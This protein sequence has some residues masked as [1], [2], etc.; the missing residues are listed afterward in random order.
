M[1][2]DIYEIDLLATGTATITLTDDGTG[3]DWLVMTGF[4]T[5]ATD[6]RLGWTRP[7]GTSTSASGYYFTPSTSG[8]I[9][10]RLVVNGLIENV[11]GSNGAD[12]IQGNEVGN[13]LYGDALSGG[14]GGNDTISAGEGNDSIYAGS[15]T[16]T[17]DGDSGNDVIFGG[18]G[19]DTVNGAGGIDTLQGGLGADVMYG[20]ADAGDTVSYTASASAVRVT[21]THGSAT[22]GLGG[23][24]AGDTIG[25]FTNVI[26]SGHNDILSDSVK[27][28]IAFGYN[29]NWFFGG[30]GNDRLALGGG[31]DLGSGGTGNDTVLGEVGNDTLKGDDGRDRVI[32]GLGADRLYGGAEADTFVYLALSD[33]TVAATGR[34]IIY[35]FRRPEHDRIDLSAIDADSD[36]DGNQTFAFVAGGPFANGVAGQVRTVIGTAGTTVFADVNGDRVADFSILLSG[37]FMNLLAEDFIL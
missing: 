21:I 12:D 5:S 22:T 26:G 25:G 28:T 23:D 35:D 32:G 19:A 31:N 4:Y 11:R 34:D 14:P 2:N 7:S 9:G 30:A 37:I 29:D 1:A 18:Q 33:S 6:I 16:D 10:H 3:S 13:I 17:V 8:N 20:G 36:L 15:G 27:T 24:A